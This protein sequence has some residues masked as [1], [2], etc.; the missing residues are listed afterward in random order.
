MRLVEKKC[1]NCGANLEFSETDKSCKCSYCHRA[2][3]IERDEKKEF[4]NYADQFNL[5]ELQ[6]SVVTASK[7]IAVPFVIVGIGFIF[8]FGLIFY[9]AFTNIHEVKSKNTERLQT[10]KEDNQILSSIDEIDNDG[11]EDLNFACFSFLSQSVVGRS[12]TT[13]SYQSAGDSRLEKVYVASKKDSNYVISI[14]SKVYHNFFNQSDQHTVYIP[15]VFENIKKDCDFSNGK[16]PAPE[17]YFNEEKSSYIYA[18]GS[19]ED[20]YNNVVKVLE[21]DYTISEK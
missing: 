2:F 20:A 17:Y 9:S 7:F 12:D 15:I 11:F 19:F 8:I 5:N 16:N 3:E 4:N 21:S 13:Y 18:Y 14:Y 1:P 6:N 10:I